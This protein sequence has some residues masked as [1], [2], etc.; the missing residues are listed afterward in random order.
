MELSQAARGS[1]PSG[2][3]NRSIVFGKL[4]LSFCT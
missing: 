3:G 2:V 1:N 4:Q